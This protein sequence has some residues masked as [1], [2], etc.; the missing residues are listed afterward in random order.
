MCIEL[1]F[2]FVKGKPEVH[3]RRTVNRSKDY[4]T[5]DKKKVKSDQVADILR[6]AGLSFGNPYYIIKQGKVCSSFLAPSYLV[7]IVSFIS[8]ADYTADTRYC[9]RQA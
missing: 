5:Y 9:S 3:L 4:Y 7:I 1:L 6:S 8:F 2:V